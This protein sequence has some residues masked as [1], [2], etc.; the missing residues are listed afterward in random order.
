MLM[1]CHPALLLLLAA[2]TV[3]CTGRT[4]TPAAVPA[5]E[6][7]ASSAAAIARAR[8]DSARYPYTAA[9]IAFMQGMIGHHAQAIVMSRLAPDRSERA[10]IRT[11]AARIINAQQDEIAIMERWLRDRR[12][13]VA[14]TSMAAHQHMGHAM[15]PGMLTTEQL[16][17]LEAARGEEFDRR[18]LRLMI[19]HHEGAVTMVTDLFATDGAAQDQTVFR[20]ASDA[21]V[22]QR[23]EI[24]RMQ[25]MLAALLFA[26]AEP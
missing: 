10:A 4:P 7:T 11:L 8:A 3:A 21:Q 18:F 6:A 15:M 12:Q 22:D 25:R 17:E 2:A 1:R 19:Q 16:A 9:D 24:A 5:P 13:P 20:F 14:D 26:Q 23:T